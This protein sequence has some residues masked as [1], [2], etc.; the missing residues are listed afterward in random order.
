MRVPGQALLAQIYLWLMACAAIGAQVYWLAAWQGPVPSDLGLIALMLVLAILA[1]HFPVAIGP[2]RKV[3]VSVA[4]YFASMLLFGAPMAVALVGA[5]HL[6]GQLTLTLRRNPATGNRMRTVRSA[7]FNTSQAMVA[8][9]LG[10]LVY[11]AF[12]PEQVPA[13]MG[14]LENVWALPAA[15]AVMYLVNTFAVAVMAGLQL[16]Q[17]P[18]RVWTGARTR[19]VVEFA[20]LFLIGVVI[21]RAGAHDPLIVLALA[22]PAALV[23]WSMDRTVRVEELV[24]REAEFAAWR[25]LDR[26]K[27]EFTRSI[28]HELRAPLALVVGFAELLHD[29][30]DGS[31]SDPETAEL[32]EQIHVNAL[33]LQ[34]L[35]D[36][37]LDFAKIERGEI[38]VQPED[39][40]LV[41]L[42][43]D[44]VAG[45]RRQSGG[46][47]LVRILP[48]TLW[49]RADRVRVAQAVYNL[50]ANAQK[51][52]PDG[53][54]TL[55]AGLVQSQNGSLPDTVRIEV[56][57]HGPGISPEEQPRVWQKFYRGR[58]VSGLN[59]APGA[60]IGLAIVKALVEAQQGHV[61]L[62]SQLGHGAR[63]WIDLP[64]A[65]RPL[66]GRSAQRGAEERVVARLV[67]DASESTNWGIRDRGIRDQHAAGPG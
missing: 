11:Y 64:A 25:D 20:S 43:Q 16:H 19:N 22:L 27:T 39:F 42:L 26:M 58:D 54:I 17:N 67:G 34:R 45:L 52:A 55:R 56:E 40:D 33:L 47:R 31:A 65:E 4:A 35:V 2:R 62:E 66:P 15:A 57:D 7:L 36:D 3:D 23:C 38:V 48:G 24:R 32:A 59:L 51:Y 30:T 8:T 10:A 50:L 28:S 18:F 6:T 61:G 14:R 21:A 53:S 9:A 37:L 63:F 12:V 49:V 60:G 13:P 29:Q 44:L 1:Q 46:E 5:S 41:P